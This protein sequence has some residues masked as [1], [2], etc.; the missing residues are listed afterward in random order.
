MADRRSKE[1]QLQSRTAVKQDAQTAAAMEKARLKDEAKARVSS[2]VV[3][4]TVRSK[5]TVAEKKQNSVPTTTILSAGASNKGSRAKSKE[6]EFFTATAITD[7]KKNK[8]E[9]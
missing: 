2:P 1:Q 9:N 4:K 7:K 8:G 5:E 6:P 3:Q